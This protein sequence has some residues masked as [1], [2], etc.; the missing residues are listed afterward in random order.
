MKGYCVDVRG[1][2]VEKKKLVGKAIGELTKLP[3]Y[4]EKYVLSFVD[5]IVNIGPP[6]SSL[7]DSVECFSGMLTPSQVPH[8]ISF[9][10]LMLEAGFNYEERGVEDFGW[11]DL[12]KCTITENKPASNKTR[13]Q[14][15][16]EQYG[17]VMAQS[18]K[19][20]FTKAL[21]D[22]LAIKKE[23]LLDESA[24]RIKQLEK[25]NKNLS[26]DAEYWRKLWVKLDGLNDEHRQS[27]EKHKRISGVLSLLLISSVAAQ[28]AVIFLR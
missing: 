7:L 22:L 10:E 15:T 27:L 5:K 8:Q 12:S 4:Y 28:L 3:F 24:I 18:D 19:R 26:D 23:Q 20:T 9:N 17:A 1:F 21:D 2:N 25:C 11:I 16:R 6:S 13:P 14:I